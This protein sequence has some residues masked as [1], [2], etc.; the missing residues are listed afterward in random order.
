MARN[1]PPPDPSQH[2]IPIQPVARPILCNPFEEPGRHWVYDT[3][4]GEAREEHGRRPASYWYKS[5]RTSSG[6]L[7]LL[8]EEERDDLPLVNLLREDVRRWREA[9]YQNA[10]PVT[11][12]LLMHWSRSDRARRL[13]FCQREAVETVIYLNEILGS[14]KRGFR[15]NPKL[16]QADYRIL[17]AG[18]RPSF[19]FE[20][21]PKVMPTLADKPNEDGLR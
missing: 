14:G 3:S 15:A 16:S 19:V 13:F 17:M 10:T 18:G 7:F 21:A 2:E 4:T 9:N 20:Q 1:S 5:E 6:Q 8:A 12:Q 11:R